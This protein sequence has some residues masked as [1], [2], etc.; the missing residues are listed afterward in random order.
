MTLDYGSAAAWWLLAVVPVSCLLAWTA[1]FPMRRRALYAT[2]R[3]VVLV[4]LIGALAQPVLSRP[5]SRLAIIYLVDTS[6][7]VSASA[8]QVAAASIDE[9][10]ASLQPDTVRILAF[11]ARAAAVADTSELRRLA[12]ASADN[13]L[14]RLVLPDATNLEQ[15]LAAARARS[16]RVRTGEF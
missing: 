4:C 7:S 9:M 8:R 16:L 5:T 2:V 3:S 15:A 13:D 14:D 1:R 12:A 11:G 6:H 10:N